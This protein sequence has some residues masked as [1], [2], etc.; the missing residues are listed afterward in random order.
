VATHA[1]ADRV[2]ERTEAAE[3]VALAFDRISLG[4]AAKLTPIATRR[5]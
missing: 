5:A 3:L 4:E 2:E 1:H